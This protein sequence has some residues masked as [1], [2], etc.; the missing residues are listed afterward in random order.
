MTNDSYTKIKN[1]LIT[2]SEIDNYEFR[3]L[4]YLISKSYTSI[5]YPSIRTIG[6][7]LGLGYMTVQRK[8]KSLEDKKIIIRNNRV[9]GTGKKTSNSYLINEDAISKNIQKD[10]NAKVS[11]SVE[12]EI[13]DE[14]LELSN[15]DWL[16]ENEE[17]E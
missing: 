2:S 15:Y 1:T 6:D 14:Q 16:N 4:V 12:S 7:E 17:Q 13:T 3:I 8:I 11:N 5:C 10:I 9:I